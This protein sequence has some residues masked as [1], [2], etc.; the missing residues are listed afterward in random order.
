MRNRL[1]QG[2]WKN[3]VGKAVNKK[4]EAKMIFFFGTSFEDSFLGVSDQTAKSILDC[5]F[6]SSQERA[7][8]FSAD[9]AP[10]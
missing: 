2:T 8:S 7:L 5:F 4:F 1:T 6:F 3:K 10:G 9:P